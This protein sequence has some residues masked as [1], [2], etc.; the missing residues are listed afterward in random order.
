MDIDTHVSVVLFTSVQFSCSVV[1]NSLQPHGLQH[2]RL[3]CPSP[4]SRAFSNS[5]PLSQWSHPTISSSVIRFS[6]RLQSFPEAGS[7]P[8]SQFFTSDG[9]S[10]GVSALASV[11]PMNIQEN[12]KHYFASM[13]DKGN[14]VVVW[15][16]FGIFSLGT[17]WKLTFSCPVAPAEF[18]KFAGILSV[19]LSQH[20]LLGF[21]I[22]QQESHHLQY[23]CS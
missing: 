3:P 18:S 9:Q 16:F 19:A 4:T 2:A 8:M 5:C 6:S 14:Y 12:F 7:F 21:E 1:S 22:A 11:L 13:W 20:H 15:P 23:L 17:E 10:I